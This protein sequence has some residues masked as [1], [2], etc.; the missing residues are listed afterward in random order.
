[1]PTAKVRKMDVVWLKRDVRLHDHAPLSAAVSG[2]KPFCV[3]YVYE[4]DQLAHHSVHGSHVHFANE[5]LVDL[6]R[7]ISGMIGNIGPCITICEGEITDI[8][9]QLDKVRKIDRILAHEETG[10]NVSY[11]RD[12]RVRKWC[13]GKQIKFIEFV[14]TGV[15]RGLKNRD[16]FT[17]NFNAF[18]ARNLCMKPSK[19]CLERQLLVSSVFGKLHC[20]IMSPDNLSSIPMEHRKDRQ[21]RQHGGESEAL[22]ILADFLN[23]R[24]Q[25]Y[26]KGISSPNESW[27]SCSRLSPYLTFGHISLRSVLQNLKKR[28][29]NERTKRKPEKSA[30]S[31]NKS[32]WLR[33]LAAFSSR[34]RWR[35]HFIQKFE[36][37]CNMEYMAQC[38]AYNDVRRSPGDWRE[39]YF[40]AWKSGKTGFPM[41]DACIRC[42]ERHGWVNFR[43]RAMV[44]SFA[45][46]NLFLDWR[47]IAPHLA[48]LFLDYEPGIHYP[49]LQMQSGVTGINAMRVY[50][51]TKQ[52]HDQDP[53]G[54]F[55]RK[56][57]PE[58]KHVPTKYIHEPHK[59][60]SST[61]AK[62]GK[63]FT[64]YPK[65]IVD[66]KLSA[67][68]A[69][70]IISEIKKRS[71]TRDEAR[72]VFLKHG[73]RKNATGKR[74]RQVLES[75]ENSPQTSDNKNT[76]GTT[77]QQTIME[78]FSRA[79]DSSLKK[80]NVSV[81]WMCSFCT[82]SNAKVEAPICEMCQ[83]KRIEK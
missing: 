54:I 36:A 68:R 46:Y 13:I 74:K 30:E 53:K 10:H 57:V 28:Q 32:D 18:M 38:L 45:A 4:P 49:Q 14:Q 50:N 34:L 2:S 15:T 76:K 29:I 19:Q 20:G 73:S 55:I 21:S 67:K 24:G 71:K 82:F 39:D 9:S 60:P 70:D 47:G 7:N 63:D 27:H 17:R 11:A 8:L 80:K 75:A 79:S 44:V 16:N 58:L 65:P 83:S 3:L 5:G 26:S 66:E 61:A 40:Q 35:S 62:C 42:L 78:V 48:R 51:V 69:K 33:S 6:D 23:R 56:H 25:G 43:M 12:R 81:P 72:Q 1:M 52:A 64:L 31:K 37:E 41:V 59:M 77:S 22:R